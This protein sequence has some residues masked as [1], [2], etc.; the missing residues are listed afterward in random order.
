MT[1]LRTTPTLAVCGK[2]PGCRA[3]A[4]NE[5]LLRTADI[6][7]VSSISSEA[8]ISYGNTQAIIAYDLGFRKVFA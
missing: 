5:I 6:S 8:G 1:R 2:S 7:G 3:F 4:P